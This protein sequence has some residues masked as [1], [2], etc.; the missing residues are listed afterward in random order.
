[1]TNR[2]SILVG[3][4]EGQVLDLRNAA[5][6][7]QFDLNIGQAYRLAFTSRKSP[8]AKTAVN[9]QVWVDGGFNL[10]VDS[11]PD[12]VTNTTSFVAKSSRTA[13]GFVATSPP[14]F[15]TNFPSGL[16]IGQ[17]WLDQDGA[18]LVSTGGTAAPTHGSARHRVVETADD[19]CSRW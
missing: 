10:R 5:V 7:R 11:T 15:A 1:M 19:R 2:V 14:T 12:W 3:G 9:A 16:E 17:V 13:I 18:P 8:A 4:R 6:E